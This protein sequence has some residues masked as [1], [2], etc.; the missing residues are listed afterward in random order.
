MRDSNSSIGMQYAIMA[1][2]LAGTVTLHAEVSTISSL[3]ATQSFEGF[4][5]SLMATGASSVS[6]HDRKLE[7]K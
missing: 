3:H 7:E 6:Q 5:K 1:V 4:Q 2:K